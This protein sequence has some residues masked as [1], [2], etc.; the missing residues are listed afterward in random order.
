M[1]KLLSRSEEAREEETPKRKS[2][3]KCRID[4]RDIQCSEHGG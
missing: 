4:S 3:C 2:S 1:V